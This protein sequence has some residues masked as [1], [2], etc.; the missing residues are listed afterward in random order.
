MGD[1]KIKLPPGAKCDGG[2][3]GLGGYCSKCPKQMTA[4]AVPLPEP[5]AQGKWKYYAEHQMHANA[6][7][8]S[9]A[10]NAALRADVARLTKIIDDAW[11]DA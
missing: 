9:A 4:T 7:E 5:V 8:V 3:C 2:T 6:A 1:A 11:G 10:D